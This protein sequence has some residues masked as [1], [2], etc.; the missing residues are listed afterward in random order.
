MFSEFQW[1][2][3]TFKD[4]PQKCKYFQGLENNL[5]QIQWHFQCTFIVD[6][7]N[8]AFILLGIER[9]TCVN[10]LPIGC[11]QIHNNNLLDRDSEIWHNLL[12]TGTTFSTTALLEESQKYV[13]DLK[14]EYTCPSKSVY[15]N[16]SVCS[17]TYKLYT[18]VLKQPAGFFQSIFYNFSAQL[19]D[20]NIHWSSDF[21]SEFGIFRSHK[22]IF[23]SSDV[24]RKNHI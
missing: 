24:R 17:K 4:L 9:H 20:T 3:S 23:S 21:Y 2:S 18:M 16:L 7:T 11:Y 10:T 12:I 22:L 6:C 15:K 5:S 13:L 8:P 14:D 19:G 1:K